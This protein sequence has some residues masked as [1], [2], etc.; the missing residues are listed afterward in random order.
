MLDKSGGLIFHVLNRSVRR[1]RIFCHDGDFG[2]FE[3]LLAEALT[4]VPIRLL[5]YCVMPSHWHLVLWPNSDEMPRFM[6][7]L[8][9]THAKRWH[10]ARGSEGTGPLY[11]NRYKAI[12]IQGDNHFLTL[13][14]YVERNPVR[15]G[16]AKSADDWRWSSMWR[17]HDPRK[18][19]QLTLWPLPCPG[20]WVELV[21]QP[22]TRAELEE[23]QAAVTHGRPL[24]D[25]QWSA[26]AAE[27]LSLKVGRPGRPKTKPG[28]VFDDERQKP[29]PVSFFTRS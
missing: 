12:P 17:R 7:W 24:G 22:H 21:N 28:L 20:N 4:R 27:R 18:D 6:H 25:A 26:E 1:V 5:G 2:A 14:R 11:Q 16:L 13:M 15:A 19:L 29:N 10:R 3:D 9:L 8:T 23:V